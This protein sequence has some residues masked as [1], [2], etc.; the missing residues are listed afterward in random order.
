MV[1]TLDPARFFGEVGGEPV[2][3]FR[4]RHA[5]GME[6]AVCNL[7]AKVLQILVPDRDGVPGDVA[8]GYDSLSAV[9]AGAPSMG[10]FIGRYAGR[11]G[12]ARYTLDG[13]AYALEPNA[14]PHSIH[15]GP[16]GSRHRV[17]SAH[18]D[19]PASLTLRL[20]FEPSVD[21]HPGILD[22]TLTYR[23]TDGHTLVVE[24]EAVAVC[25]A[26]PASP[27]SFTPHIFF[28]LDGP[29]DRAVDGHHLKV[30]ADQLLAADADHVATGMR[31]PLDGHALDLRLPRRLG[32]L[33]DIDHTYEPTASPDGGLRQVA[34]AHSP[35]SG[36]TLAVWTTEPVMQVYTAGALGSGPA[37]DVGKHGVLHRPR[38]GLCL[39][40]QQYP[41]AMNCPAFP[42]LRVAVGQPYRARTEYRFGSLPRL[43]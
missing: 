23:L 5:S 17:F 33:P 22:L 20:R 36:R 42:L 9:Q 7:G 2:A 30:F 12:Q 37:P 4:L 1:Q 16:N 28:N 10:A 31:T 6:V 35:A 3:M 21:G 40:P 13:T 18:Q 26:S 19:T 34:H 25:N 8:L 29:G 11:I 41:N 14:G 27:A 15:G 39:E 32:E 43:P 38:A 24:H